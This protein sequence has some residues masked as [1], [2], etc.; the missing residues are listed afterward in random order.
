MNNELRSRVIRLL[1]KG[2]QQFVKE[3][4][5]RWAQ[6]QI[7]RIKSRA[8]PEH[9]WNKPEEIHATLH[10]RVLQAHPTALANVRN[11]DAALDA[12]VPD[13]A[14]TLEMLC[15]ELKCMKV[16]PSLHVRYESA[17][18]REEHFRSIDA[19]LYV[20]ALIFERFQT[21]IS[22][23]RSHVWQLQ[24]FANGFRT[25]NSKFIRE[26]SGL[27]LA[28][29]YS[30]NMNIVR[31]NPLDGSTWSPLPKFLANKTCHRECPQHRQPMLR[32]SRWPR[33]SIR[34]LMAQSRPPESL[35]SI[36]R[37]A[38]SRPS[39][40]PGQPDR[41]PSDRRAAEYQYQS[42]QLL[43]RR[44]S[45]SISVVYQSAKQSDGD[46]SPLLRRSLRLD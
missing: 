6:E 24:H 44:G 5:R 23:E 36:L 45:R 25:S 28:E 43:R 29:I 7:D 33:R 9:Y 19:H 1:E 4:N 37:R 2:K 10:F 22:G 18:P 35:S 15:E 41:H 32:I 46:R 11:L 31:F 8:T 3:E 27:I 13:I 39:S 34:L 12:L 30:L 16:W 26:K 40:I 20:S 42:H 17:N 14:P 21:S 38:R